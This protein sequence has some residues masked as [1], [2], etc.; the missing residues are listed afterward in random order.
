MASSL[1]N[2]TY[3]SKWRDKDHGVEIGSRHLSFRWL[4]KVFNVKWAE[5]STPTVREILAAT[6]FQIV[7]HTKG[8]DTIEKPHL[9]QIKRFVSAKGSRTTIDFDIILNILESQS[10]MAKYPCGQDTIAFYTP[11]EFGN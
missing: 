5:E 11:T 10:E 6:Y 2:P 1:N 3:L 8:I 7:K 4:S 9:Y